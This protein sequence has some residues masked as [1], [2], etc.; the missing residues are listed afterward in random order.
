MVPIKPTFQK[1]AR[2]VRDLS[3][4]SDKSIRLFTSGDD[5][6]LDKRVVDKLG[7]PLIHLIRN[8][9]D[10]GLEST[11]ERKAAGKPPEGRITL[12]AFHKGGSI[13]IEVADDGR[14]LD[15][16][17]IV[18]KA[19]SLGLVREDEELNDRN[20]YNLIFEPGFSTAERVTGVSGRGVGMDVVRRTIEDLRGMVAV[21]SERGV[22][23]VHSIRLPLTLA[24][25]EGMIVGV[26][27]ERYVL[28]TLSIIR[29]FRP[30]PGS[31][32]TVVGKGKMI[33]QNGELI[34][35]ISLGGLFGVR[36]NKTGF[37][38]GL[39][40]V[41][42]SEGRRTGLFVDELLGHQQIVIKSLGKSMQGIPGIS[43]GAIMGD[44]RISLIL[45]VSGLVNISHGED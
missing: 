27:P 34:P 16:D 1:M 7:D 38:D 9:V 10:H 4:K 25:I 41:V 43:G 39:V 23:T 32:T 29:S 33:S 18:E 12:S 44:G 19:A 37:V 21:N 24:I 8:A 14:G 17:A 5:T 26:G 30:T 15:R 3:R 36:G 40:V 45:D 35:L 6:E 2:L 22:G 31:V 20:V 11:R 42:E 28:P 13:H